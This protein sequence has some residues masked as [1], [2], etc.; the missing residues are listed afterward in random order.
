MTVSRQ[1]APASAKK[2]RWVSLARRAHLFLSVF[3]SPLLILFIVTGWWQ[4]AVSRYDQEN[5]TGAFHDLM[6]NLSNVHTDHSY[7]GFHIG[8]GHAAPSLIRELVIAMAAALLLSIML[9]LILAWQS[10]RQK[11]IVLLCLLLG[12]AVP[13]VAIYFAA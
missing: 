10:L 2:I 6:S 12:I 13:L 8:H 7:P 3:F 5:G 4:T 9:G 1:P 11:W